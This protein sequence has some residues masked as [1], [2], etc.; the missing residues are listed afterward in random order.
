MFGLFRITLFMVS[1]LGVGV[2]AVVHMP[3]TSLD[4]RIWG[5][6]RV[7][8]R[9]FRAPRGFAVVDPFR[10]DTRYEGMVWAH[11]A[12]PRGC[13]VAMMQARERSV[14]LFFYLGAKAEL[15]PLIDAAR[16]A[17]DD[18]LGV[19]RLAPVDLTTS[20]GVTIRVEQLHQRDVVH[21]EGD[22][23]LLLGTADLGERL[24]VV[25]GG[26]RTAQVDMNVLLDAVRSVELGSGDR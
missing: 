9:W 13:A 25:N 26:G 7:D 20:N 10:P 4:K 18:H 11:L 15:Q 17:F 24:L 8:G 22:R 14:E 21:P 23:M 16:H 2:A 6:F 5:P 12:P 3:G 19:E 1:M